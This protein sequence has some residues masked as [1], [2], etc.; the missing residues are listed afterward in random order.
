[1]MR[2]VAEYWLASQQADGLLPYG[3]DFLTGKADDDVTS[4]G[5]IAREAGAIWVWAR[6]YDAVRDE[7]YVVPLQ[8]GL[9]ALASRSIAFGKPRT[10]WLLDTLRVYQVPFGRMTLTRALRSAGLLY[11]NEGSARALTASG[12]DGAWTGSTALALLAELEYA[13]ATGDQRFAASRNAWRDALI[14]L[15]V[16]GY[17]FRD[18]P[19]SIDDDDDYAAGEAWLALATYSALNPHDDRVRDVLADVDRA[20]IVRLTRQPSTPTFQWSSMAALQR[21]RTTRDP[22][23][24]EFARDQSRVFITRLPRRVGDDPYGNR[25]AWLEGFGAMRTLLAGAGDDVTGLDAAIAGE[26]VRLPRLQITGEPRMP[27]GGGGYLASPALPR[28]AGAFLWQEY[29]RDTRVDAEAHCLS[30]L[31]LINEKSARSQ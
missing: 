26:A 21:W 17:G 18:G 16:P 6:Y 28:F 15:Y 22:R 27:L 10:Q 19:A 2:A 8:R 23:F 25:C 11:T 4:T 12:L 24:V 20:L 3:F 30:A 1:M 14:A 13:R 9:Q 31:L 29:G 7:R 5:F